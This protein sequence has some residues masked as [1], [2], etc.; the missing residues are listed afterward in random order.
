MQK[1]IDKLQSELDREIV[2]TRKVNGRYERMREQ[3]KDAI[4]KAEH[5]KALAN[6]RQEYERK[7][8][9]MKPRVHN[10]RGGGRKR[11]ASKE[12]VDKAIA[13]YSEGLT[14]LKIAEI[15]SEEY[16][17]KIGRTTIG[18]IVRGE[19]TPLDAE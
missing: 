13:L 8:S 17:I 19:Y 12:V 10:E 7:L 18:D 16:G 3:L 14:Q 15:L 1:T 6:L 9:G 4:P 5:E 11:V 2:Y